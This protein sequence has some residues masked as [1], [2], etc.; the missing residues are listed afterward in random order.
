MKKLN[1]PNFNVNMNAIKDNPASQIGLFI[2]LAVVVTGFVAYLIIVPIVANANRDGREASIYND[3]INQLEDL[4]ADTESVRSE[5]ESLILGSR[6]NIL[7]MVPADTDESQL[8]IILD[9]IATR[10]G[11]QITTYT[12]YDFEESDDGV[13]DL[14]DSDG[15]S[16]GV[17]SLTFDVTVNGT[18]ENIRDFVSELENGPRLFSFL[19]YSLTRESLDIVAQGS[20]SPVMAAL[21]KIS[22]PFQGIELPRELTEALEEDQD[23]DSESDEGLDSDLTEDP[24]DG[25]V[26]GIEEE[27]I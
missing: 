2:I 8:L 1:K 5:Y 23:A 20:D 18:Y 11:V 16:F 6:D 19:E 12:P 22:T 17:Q 21:F 14:G 3:R 7:R 24:I 10:N 4:A 26:D 27:Q 13:E 25:Q 15:S 9:K